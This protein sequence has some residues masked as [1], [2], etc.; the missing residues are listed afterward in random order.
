MHEV[1]KY[2]ARKQSFSLTKQTLTSERKE[3]KM[4]KYICNAC[5]RVVKDI[6]AETLV[7]YKGLDHEDYILC[8]TCSEAIK[9]ELEKGGRVDDK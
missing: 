7:I 8:P 1:A 3:N 9:K 4:I 6:E 2:L 5:G